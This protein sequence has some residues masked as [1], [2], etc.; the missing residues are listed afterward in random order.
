MI[1]DRTDALQKLHSQHIA[2]AEEE[3]KTNGHRQRADTMFSDE[4][5][6]ELCRSAKNAPKFERLYDV[7]DTSEYDHDD[8]RADQGLI[9]L[10]AFYTQDPEQLDR[11]FQGSALYRAEKWGRRSDYRRRTI[12]KALNGVTETYSPPGGDPKPYSSKNGHREPSSRRP[13]PYRDGT[14]GRKPEAVKLADVEPP[15]ARRYILRG[16]VPAPYVTLFYGDGGVAKSLLALA[17][18]LAVACGFGKWLGLETEKGSVLYFDAELDVG[19]QVRRAH[20]LRCG[21]GLEELPDGLLYMS[22]LGFSIR[23]ALAAAL[24]TCKEHGVKLLVLD[25]LGPALEGDAEDAKNVIGFFQDFIEPF[26]ALGVAVLIIDHQSKLQ[27]GQSY[28]SKGAFGSV[29]KSNLARSVLQVEATERGEGTL[30]VRVRQKK[31]N[32]GPL[33]EPFGIKLDFSERAVT[34]EAV[35]L[36]AAELAEEATLNARERVKLALAEGPAYPWE[37]A[38]AT[39]ILLKTVKNSL[40]GLR[41]QGEVEPTGETEG[42]T[43]QVRLSVP[44]SQS[45]YRD[46]TRDDSDP[47]AGV[48]VNEHG[49][50]EF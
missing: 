10:M 46:G 8:S 21:L 19:E 40:T 41:K 44:A 32:F 45:P 16:L 4:E 1:P 12:E 38:E 42:R 7:G 14:V 6:I 22:A 37:I 36:K 23:E 47:L 28:Q 2:R 11:L 3:P 39:G 35:E 13:N 49:E 34:L 20:Q 30:T 43:Q 25:S 18:A 29:F 26:R 9:S 17:F 31:H 50:A 27:A 5:V 24:E 48:H 15:G 33:A